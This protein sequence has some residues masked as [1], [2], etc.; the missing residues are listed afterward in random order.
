MSPF[1]YRLNLEMEVGKTTC[2]EAADTFYAALVSFKNYAIGAKQETPFGPIELTFNG[3][4]LDDLDELAND[5]E[6]DVA[7]ELD[8]ILVVFFHPFQ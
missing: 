8:L 6:E 7:Q 3:N 4:D 1:S 5:V 2:R